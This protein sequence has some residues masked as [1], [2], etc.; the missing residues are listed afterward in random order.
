MKGLKPYDF[1]HLLL[2]AA[3]GRIQ[4]RTKLQ[5]MAYFTAILTG[6]L[7]DLGFKPHFYGPYSPLVT[8][9]LDEL[10]SVGF[11]DQRIQGG[12]HVDPRGFELARY[13][14]V[15]T[16]DGKQI[17][18][19]KAQHHPLV[20]QRIQSAVSRLNQA[21]VSDYVKLSIAAKAYFM[22]GKANKPVEVPD[23]VK[24]S[25]TFGWKVSPNQIGEAAEW[26]KS[27]GLVEEQAS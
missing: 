2:H 21:N 1:V 9:A 7:D 15:L 11:L 18:E 8:G 3:G 10:R 24:M 17:A 4:G 26:L 22:V 25:E 20:W 14:Y 6:M 12:G 23:L 19:E 13:D 27:L 16:D 5:K